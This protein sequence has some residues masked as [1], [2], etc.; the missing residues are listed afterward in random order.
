MACSRDYHG[1]LSGFLVNFR[2]RAMAEVYVELIMGGGY[3]DVVLLVRGQ[4]NLN[5]SVPIV[6][7]LKA[8]S[9]NAMQGLEQARGYVRNGPISSVPIHTSSV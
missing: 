6:I 2:Y 4:E 7:E 5:D 8:G 1:F 3:A 9:E